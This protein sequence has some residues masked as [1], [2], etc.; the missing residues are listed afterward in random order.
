VVLNVLNCSCMTKE[1]NST[2]IALIPKVSN[3]ACINGFRPISLCN[4]FYKLISKV[5]ANR[6][7]SVLP[8]IISFHQSAFIPRRLITNNIL[9]AYEI[10]HT[11]CSNMWENEGYML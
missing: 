11:M 6:L 1:L 9:A 2:Y 10:L 5:L 3:P 4:V 7:I 8:E